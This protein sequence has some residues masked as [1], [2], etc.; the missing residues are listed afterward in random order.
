NVIDGV[1]NRGMTLN[2]A[3]DNSGNN[4]LNVTVT[5]NNVEADNPSG[6]EGIFVQGGTLTGNDGI[7]C[8]DISSNTAVS[9]AADGLRV[10]QRMETTIQLPGYTGANNNNA[11]VVAYLQARNPSLGDTVS[12]T[13]SVGVAP[14]NGPGGGFVNTPGPGN[15]CAQPTLP[16]A[17]LRLEFAA[18]GADRGP[19][20]VAVEEAAQGGVTSRPFVSF[21]QNRQ[22]KSPALSVAPQRPAQKQSGA[23][24]KAGKAAVKAPKGGDT[25]TAPNGRK[26]VTRRLKPVIS[27]AGETINVKIGTLRS[28]DSVEITFQATVADPYTGGPNVSNQG[29]VTADNGISVQTDDPGDATSSSDPT[30]TPVDALK[31]FVMDATA[32]EPATGTTDMVFT[33]TLSAPAPGLVSVS[34]TTE[35]EPAGPGKAVAGCGDYTTSTGVLNFTTGQQ[36]QSINVPVCSDADNAEPDETFLVK[37][38]GATGATIADGTATGTITATNPPGA[39]LISEL[40]T[41]GPGGSAD[42]FVEIYNNSDTKHIVDSADDTGYGL[43]KMGA[44][45]GDTP[46]LIGTIS[47]GTEIDPRGHFLFVGTQYS[48]ADYGGT[49]ATDGDQTMSSDIEDNRNVAIFK[50]AD[51]AALSS[52]NRLDAVG[53]GINTGT[54]CNLL[55]EGA[56]LAPVA[57]NFPGGVT[58]QYT[59]FRSMCSFVG[60]VGCTVVG[61]SK[62]TNVNASDFLF[63][64]VEATD[65]SAFGA[66]QR[67]GAPGPEEKSSPLRKNSGI[68]VLPLD[69]SQPLSAGP[70]RSRFPQAQDPG[71]T[72][73][74]LVVRRRIENN[75]SSTV[76]RLRFRIVEITTFPPAPG[77]ADLRARDSTVPEMVSSIGDAETCADTSVPPG[78]PNPCTVEVMPTVV[79]QPPVQPNGGGFNSTMTVTLVPGIAPGDSI[80]VRFRL[81]LEQTGTFRFYMIVEALP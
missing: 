76:T 65:M 4:R 1:A 81:G 79:E 30:L 6:F 52:V 71:G 14:P 68:D 54:N 46:V 56:T 39:I 27:A 31:I 37:L 66:G 5:G 73:G 22:Q 50:T 61:T 43:F 53:F 24:A 55:R 23:A 35:E 16:S 57:G 36:V 63:A 41:S 12:A 32:A 74:T 69:R 3:E 38:S 11:A 17:P 62:D 20:K 49:D 13:N 19:S 51:P 40:R 21:P 60:G 34:F 29:T 64:D 80:N 70:N 59:F 47:E 58:T 33:V 42:D 26:G 8:A 10:R 18:A 67:L 44:G 15:P 45:C 25:P 9:A 48:L 2:M 75:T 7:I 77:F 78:T 28:G 72:H